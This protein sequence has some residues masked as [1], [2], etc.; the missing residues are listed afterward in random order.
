M[1]FAHSVDGLNVVA[2]VSRVVHADGA[3][4]NLTHHAVHGQTLFLVFATHHVSEVPSLVPQGR[5]AHR[6]LQQVV[7]GQRTAGRMA[8]LAALVTI[9]HL[10]LFAQHR[11]VGSRLAHAQLALRHNLPELTVPVDDVPHGPVLRQVVGAVLVEVHGLLAGRTR[12]R[13]RAGCDRRKR[14]TTDDATADV[15]RAH[16]A[17][18][19]AVAHHAAVGLAE[20]GQLVRLRMAAVGRRVR[21]GGATAAAGRRAAAVFLRRRRFQGTLSVHRAV[22]AQGMV[23]RQ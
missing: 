18:G 4:R 7:L 19:P 3:H 14:G 21:V 8:A 10:A 16:I 12:Q 2:R 9:Q 22:Q 20:D 1:G 17:V 5:L 11:G 15:R 13:I 6:R 23:A